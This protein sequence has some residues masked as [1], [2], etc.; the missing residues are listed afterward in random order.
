MVMLKNGS[1][2]VGASLV[3]MIVSG[4]SLKS[5]NE[6][7]SLRL[8]LSSLQD[9]S[10]Q[11]AL[12]RS[13]LISGLTTP[14]PQS[15]TAFSCYGVNVTG[16]GIMDS[17][18]HPEADPMLT[19]EKT[20]TIPGNYCS[21]RGVL[22]PPIYL[23][24]TGTAE[25]GMQVP[26]GGVRLVQVVGVNDATVCASGM[27]GGNDSGGGG[28]KYFEI[29][30]GVLTDLFD[31]RSVEITSS[32]PTGS[33]V[34][35]DVDR[36]ARALDCGRNCVY[37]VDG[38][39][40]GVSNYG[41]SIG[42]TGG[43]GSIAQKFS[44]TQLTYLRSA[45][46]SLT[47]SVNATVTATVYMDGLAGGNSTG[48]STTANVSAGGPTMVSFDFFDSV[49]RYLA[50]DSTHFYYLVFSAN[51]GTVDFQ[52]SSL[53]GTSGDIV[54]NSTSYAGQLFMKIRACN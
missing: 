12:L 37:P 5:S 20:L 53:L 45:D 51:A 18:G 39:T 29:G 7:P 15:A 3:L 26:P 17:S 41:G 46:V 40:A 35:D 43:T 6:D 34:Q 13:G 11:Y 54:L 28:A 38:P 10:G 2:A 24:G 25:V 22:T 31:D 8:D 33:G 36:L 48:W 42:I 49:N 19:F 23:S 16:P 30:R 52:K 27:L 47:A 9:R 32:W 14:P 50:M 21:Y 44:V 4:C 1:I